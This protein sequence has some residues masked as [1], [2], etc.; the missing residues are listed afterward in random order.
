MA[1]NNYKVSGGISTADRSPTETT[2]TLK[3]VDKTSGKVEIKFESGM[4]LVTV[5]NHEKSYIGWPGD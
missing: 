5:I 2:Q 1:L 3:V 4:R